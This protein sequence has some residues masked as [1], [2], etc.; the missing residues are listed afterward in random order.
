MK[1]FGE[2]LRGEK[3]RKKTACGRGR[4]I[5]QW[6]KQASFSHFKEKLIR[7]RIQHTK[8]KSAFWY[9]ATSGIPLVNETSS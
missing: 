3:K 8:I 6:R 7:K 1:Q 9:N 5:F 2:P 4:K